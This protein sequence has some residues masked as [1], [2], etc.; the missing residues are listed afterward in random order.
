MLMHDFSS[1][2]STMSAEWGFHPDV[3]RL[4]AAHYGSIDV[5][6]AAV[7]TGSD[8]LGA[9]EQFVPFPLL[10]RS[11]F[12]N[13]LLSPYSIEHGMFAMIQSG[14]GRVANLSICRAARFGPFEP[15]NLEVLSALTPH[16]R[17]AYRLHA[18]LASARERNRNLLTAFDSSPAGVIFLDCQM[19]IVSINRSAE[20]IVAQANGLLSRARLLFAEKSSE[21]AMLNRLISAAISVAIGKGI[22]PSACMTITRRGA[23]PLQIFV[24]PLRGEASKQFNRLGAIVFVTAPA[25]CMRRCGNALH[26]CYGLTPAEARVALLLA[27]GHSPKQISAMLA[28]TG[29]TI[30]SQLK[31]VF[32]KTGVR[33]QSELVALIL[34]S[35]PPKL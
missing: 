17:R 8:W 27:D 12:Y 30:R 3:S 21:S 19:R 33:R 23:P 6:R 31:S 15:S 11:E 22:E 13:D 14:P 24:A 28:V 32:A 7:T 29:H 26:S 18:E 5:W 10:Q 9:S 4:Y 34:T 1:S 20:Q 35:K 25:Q 16:I 2:E